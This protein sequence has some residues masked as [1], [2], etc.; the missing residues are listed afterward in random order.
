MFMRTHAALVRSAC[1]AHVV[2]IVVLLLALVATR[3]AAQSCCGKLDVPLAGTERGANKGG[4]LLLGVSYELGVSNS[5]YIEQG[6]GIESAD[7]STLT[8]DASYGITRWLTPS[9]A[10]PFAYKYYG[11]LVGGQ[12]VSRSTVGVADAL[13]LVKLAVLG[14]TEMAPGALRVWF[15]P[16][17]KLPTGPYR[18]D[19]KYGRLPAAAQLGSGSYDAVAAAFASIGLAGEGSQNL[20]MLSVVGRYTTENSEGY[21]AGHSIESTLYVTASQIKNLSLRAGPQLRFG[22]RDRQSNLLLGNTGATRLSVRAGGAYSLSENS[23]LTADLQVPIYGR[24]HGNQLD[25]VIAVT[26]GMLV[27][28]P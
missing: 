14:S 10:L 6:F 8:L 7:T 15:A 13:I 11:A 22:M 5:G 19:D 2:A 9:I 17:I 23:S 4:Q 18:H 24:V 16:G 28:Y 25:P 27:S 3:A 21:R 20:L 26:L 1:A 12:D